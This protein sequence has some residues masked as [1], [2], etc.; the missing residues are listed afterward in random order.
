MTDDKILKG[1]LPHQ[2][3]KDIARFWD[4]CNAFNIDPFSDPLLVSQELRDEY[5]PQIQN[6][7]GLNDWDPEHFYKIWVLAQMTGLV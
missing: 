3:I 7:L 2:I 4:R 5:L 1:V 6:E